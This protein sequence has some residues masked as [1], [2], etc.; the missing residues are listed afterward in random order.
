[1]KFCPCFL[2]FRLESGFRK[3]RFPFSGPLFAKNFRERTSIFAYFLG[4]YVF[5]IGFWASS[6]VFSCWVCFRNFVPGVRFCMNSLSCERQGVLVLFARFFGDSGCCGFRSGSPSSP[7]P[8]SSSPFL[9]L[10]SAWVCFFSSPPPLPAGL[11]RPPQ[12]GPALHSVMSCV[13][14]LFFFSL[15]GPAPLSLPRLSLSLSLSLSL[16][17]LPLSLS[18]ACMRVHSEILPVLLGVH[19]RL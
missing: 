3:S 18:L 4:A 13:L 14:F 12:A 15:P 11:A 9:L 10:G 6:S 19:D 1:M 17:S 5:A 7:L 16:F 8:P 2:Q